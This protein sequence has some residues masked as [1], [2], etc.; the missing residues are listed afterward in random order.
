MA[1]LRYR[2]LIVLFVLASLARP[3]SAVEVED[4][5]PP[6]AGSWVV[7]SVNL[8]DP[9]QLRALDELGDRLKA[10]RGA[11]LAVVVVRTVGAREPR[12]FAVSLFNRWGVGER[13]WDNGL[14]IL[15]ALED[16]AAE[17]VLGD[18]VA[19]AVDQRRS[20]EVMQQVMLPRFRAGE[21]GLAIVDGARACAE[22]ILGLGT[23]T[24]LPEPEAAPVV[25]PAAAR[26]L[27]PAGQEPS[28][29]VAVALSALWIALVGGVVFLIRRSRRPPECPSCKLPMLL[30]DE[31]ADDA[32]LTKLEQAEE[33][34]GSVDHLVFACEAC[35][36]RSKKERRRWVSPCLVCA[37]CGARTFRRD[38]TTVVAATLEHGGRVR[39][40]EHCAFC[41]DQRTFEYETRPRERPDHHHSWA[42]GAS[43]AQSSSRSS[44]GSGS[45]SSRSSGGSGGSSSGGGASGRW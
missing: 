10:E 2:L 35:G 40:V 4:L 33:S 15:V 6:P 1:S 23:A 37:K 42:R 25:M 17:I 24:P 32:H 43:P 38:E 45:S 30:L 14:M 5:N 11:E 44:S 20:E 22:R 34:V 41:H 27:A 19:G 39:V 31:S 18:G 13:R 3:V 28:S 8:L 21:P 12:D 36:L 9:A 26:P 29:T 16:R 7:D